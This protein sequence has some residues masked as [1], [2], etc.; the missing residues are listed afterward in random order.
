MIERGREATMK[1]AVVGAGGFVGQSVIP[2]LAEDGHEIVPIV[3]TRRGL[4][5]EQPIA[6]LG[7]ANWADLLKGA[8][9]VIHLAARVHIMSDT[10][11]DPLAE[12]RRINRD[13]TLRVAHAAADA[14][15]RRFLFI[16]TIKVN[17]EETAPGSPFLRDS[18]PAP[19]DTGT[20]R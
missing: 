10:A 17:G 19:R 14:G 11:R 8:D 2:R 12:H 16:S 6:D 20:G 13:G 3:R 9:A 5:G 18:W 7:T 4:P 1:V 15:V